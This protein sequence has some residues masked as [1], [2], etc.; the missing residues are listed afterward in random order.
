M[1]EKNICNKYGRL[2]FIYI[3]YN[4]FLKIGKNEEIRN[5]LVTK[6]NFKVKYA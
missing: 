1:T 4:D 2:K 5:L 6:I 3:I